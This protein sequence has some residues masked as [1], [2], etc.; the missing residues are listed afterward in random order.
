MKHFIYGIVNPNDKQV[1][2]V[3]QTKDNNLNHY[4]NSKYWKLNEVKRGKRN[5]NKL[6]KL[7]DELLPIKLK[8]ICLKELDDSIPFN[9]PNAFEKIYIKKYREINPNLLNETDGGIGGN[10][11]KYKTEEERKLIAQKVSK[12]NKGKKKPDGFGERLSLAR[13]SGNNPAA[14]RLNIGIFENNILI[15]I[16]YYGCDVNTFLN[17][18]WFW[19]NNSNTV[20]N[21]FVATYK[22]YKIKLVEE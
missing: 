7:M 3:G 2:Y 20:Q 10:I 4:L 9:S 1:V 6:F 14:K 15:K 16:V 8:I 11:L 21:G 17:N 22:Q 13:R 18:K 19:S 5:W 12:A